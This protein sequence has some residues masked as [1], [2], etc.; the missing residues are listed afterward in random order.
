MLFGNIILHKTRF[1]LLPFFSYIYGCH[2]KPKKWLPYRGSKSQLTPI[3]LKNMSSHLSDH[4]DS[5][6]LSLPN[7]RGF[8][9][10]KIYLVL[11]YISF[12]TGILSRSCT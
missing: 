1:E 12:A 6:M 3:K 11:K 10:Y 9:I 8:V 4:K 7:V 5:K 2:V